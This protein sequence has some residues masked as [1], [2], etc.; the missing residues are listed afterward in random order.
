MKKI[1]VLKKVKFWENALSVN[2]A[3]IDA[4]LEDI[5]DFIEEQEPKIK[6]LWDND[7]SEV[8]EAEE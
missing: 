8:K 4:V 1:E 2:E 7:N 3:N 6:H 5:R